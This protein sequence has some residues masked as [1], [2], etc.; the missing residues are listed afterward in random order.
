[1]ALDG[2]GSYLIIKNRGQTASFFDRGIKNLWQAAASDDKILQGADVEDSIVGRAAA[3]LMVYGGVKS[4]KAGVL[5]ESA[6]EIFEYYKIPFEYEE[7]VPRIV[8][9]RGDDICPMEKAAKDCDPSDI[10]EAI[11]NKLKELGII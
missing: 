10:V 1:M 11:K 5:S 2:R 8:N 9:R 4:V 6:K 7:L 3:L